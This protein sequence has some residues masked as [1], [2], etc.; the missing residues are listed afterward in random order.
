[1]K[2]TCGAIAPLA[3]II[4]LAAALPGCAAY[5]IGQSSLYPADI[6]TVYVPMFDS[7]SF[8]RNLGER[9]TEAVVKE[10]ELKTPYKV[11][12]SPAADS[13]LSGR[14]VS[15]TKGVL[16]KPPQDEQRLIQSGFQ[17]EVTWADRRGGMLRDTQTLPLPPSLAIVDQ[18]TNFVPEVGQSITT[19]QQ[20]AIQ[21]LAEQIVSLMESPW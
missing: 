8:R 21:R 12:N 5:R 15:D 4:A 16:V 17:V 2:A 18:T 6:H 11:V 13:V 20:Q 1:M 10:I 14:F 19:A 7:L 3:L 9:L